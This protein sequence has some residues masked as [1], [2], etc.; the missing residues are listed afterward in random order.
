LIIPGKSR[1]SDEDSSFILEKIGG[2]PYELKSI[3]LSQV[4]LPHLYEEYK[5]N[6]I[7]N[8]IA[9]LLDEKEDASPFNLLILY[10]LLLSKSLMEGMKKERKKIKK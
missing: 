6:S 5:V 4:P 10:E 9:S 7:S 3:Y 8:L 1:F 2:N